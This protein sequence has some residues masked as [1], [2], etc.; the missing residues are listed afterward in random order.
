MTH[1]WAQISYNTQL[2]YNTTGEKIN[3][4]FYKSMQDSLDGITVRCMCVSSTVSSYTTTEMKEELLLTPAL[5]LWMVL[6]RPMS[7]WSS[8]SDSGSMWVRAEDRFLTQR[9]K[10]LP[11]V[12]AGTLRTNDLWDERGNK[13]A[14]KM[15]NAF[16]MT[17]TGQYLCIIA[18]KRSLDYECCSELGWIKFLISS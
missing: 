1:N 10:W 2:S 8:S 11:Q 4:N 6:C 5:A 17:M 9:C 7:T 15:K 13:M 14:V 18:F 16:T 3:P 12:M